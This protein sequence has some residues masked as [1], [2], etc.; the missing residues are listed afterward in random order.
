MWSAYWHHNVL[1]EYVFWL[2]NWLDIHDV[3]AIIPVRLCHVQTFQKQ[4][5]PSF[6]TYRKRSATNHRGGHCN[7]ASGSRYV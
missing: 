2:A 4:A 6:R 3:A 1:F 5:T 7:H